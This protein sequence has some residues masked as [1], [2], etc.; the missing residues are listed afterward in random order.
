MVRRVAAVP[1]GASPPA[2]GH[3]GVAIVADLNDS[4]VGHPTGADKFAKMR[5]VVGHDVSLPARV[6]PA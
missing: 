4:F 5:A 6:N 2:F 3:D 1:I